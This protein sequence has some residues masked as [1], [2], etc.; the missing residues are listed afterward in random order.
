LRDIIN[1]P[2]N[3][4]I[5]NKYYFDIFSFSSITIE[6][7]YPLPVARWSI[8]EKTIEKTKAESSINIPVSLYD[9]ISRAYNFGILT[10]DVYR[11]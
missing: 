11:K 10:V 9:P 2:P 1:N 8:Y 7:I 6:Q 5:K 4:D 3:N